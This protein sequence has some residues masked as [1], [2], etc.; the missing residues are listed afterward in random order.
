LNDI[1]IVIEIKIKIIIKMNQPVLLK[2]SH[3]FDFDGGKIF[4]IKFYDVNGSDRYQ[5]CLIIHGIRHNLKIIKMNEGKI[6]FEAISLDR[7]GD[8]YHKPM[9]WCELSD[10]DNYLSLDMNNLTLTLRED[11]MV[12]QWTLIHNRSS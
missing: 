11:A 10:L 1:P 8:E 2:I 9:F 4:R 12:N 6:Y 3:N 5:W 7:Y